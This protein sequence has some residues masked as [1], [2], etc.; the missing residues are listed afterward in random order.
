MNTEAIIYCRVSSEKQKKEGHGLDSQEHRCRQYAESEHLNVLEVFKDDISGGEAT[1][2]GM[3]ALLQFLEERGNDEEPIAVIIDDIKRWARDVEVHFYFRK[4][5]YE[6][7]G[8]LRSPNF[9]FGESPEDKFFETMMA[10][11]AELERN[12]NARQVK[13]KM[14]AR[15]ERG[16]WCFDYPPGLKYAKVAD[17]GKLLVRDDPKALTIMEALEGFASGRMNDQTDVQKFLASRHF[18]HRAKAGTVHLEQVKR[19]LTQVL[20]AG[21]VEYPEWGVT[22]RRGHH[23]GL[24][25]IE[26]FERI[27]ERLK[28]KA[29]VPQRRDLN[30]DFP[31][32]GFICC[33]AC[34]HPYTA[35]W[36]TGRGKVRHPYYRC[37]GKGCAFY[38]KSILRKTME[39]EFLTLLLQLKP[40]PGVVALTKA[41][42]LDYWK[43]EMA[44]V[45]QRRKAEEEKLE[46]IEGKIK[47]LYERIEKAKSETLI[48]GYEVRIE[49]MEEEKKQVKKAMRKFK[50]PID[51]ETALDKVMEFV[52]DPAKMWQTKDLTKQRVVL[53]LVFNEKL[54]YLRDFGF[55]TASLSLPFALSGMAGVSKSKMVEM[56]GVEPGSNV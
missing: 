25:N 1:R 42:I 17:H 43:G 38:G 6:R 22:R 34:K 56:P 48:Q 16:Y 24:I 8:V 35:N 21:Y 53:K 14:K 7:N 31:L 39:D 10:A 23:Q 9:K 13:Q 52:E 55:E 44:N 51:F 28:G 54:L 15:L 4:A 46:D 20:Y 36:S 49:Q 37:I 33:T 45:E 40:K 2:S 32:R 29:R 30:R 41:I 3:T 27:Q 50:T 12:Q 47:K 19:I 26:T 18:T 11:S 5:V